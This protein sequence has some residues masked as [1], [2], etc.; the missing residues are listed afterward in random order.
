VDCGCGGR[1]G[2]GMT[3]KGS[4]S[5]ARK[6]KINDGNWKC[7]EISMKLPKLHLIKKRT[8]HYFHKLYSFIHSK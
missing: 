5:K 2:W 1:E 4:D 7:K 8:S 6:I 3:E